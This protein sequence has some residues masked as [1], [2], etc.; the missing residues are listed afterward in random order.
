MKKY[1]VCTAVVFAVIALSSISA[2]SQDPQAPAKDDTATAKGTQAEVVPSL[3]VAPAEAPAKTDE[4][5]IYGEV[6]AVNAQ[7]ASMSVQYY[8]Y[9]NDE[10]KTLEL[11]LDKDSKLENVKAIDAVKKG[12]W[13]DVTYTVTGG[14][15]IARNVNVET[16]EVAAEDSAPVDTA[17]E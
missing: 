17:G 1:L 4:L 12:D 13:V 6:Q 5:S 7:A 10:E 15:N 14:K 16:E 3:P 11:S 8:D 9:D 2:F